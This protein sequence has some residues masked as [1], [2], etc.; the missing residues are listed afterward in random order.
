MSP[1]QT[2]SFPAHHVPHAKP[3]EHLTALRVFLSF[4]LT[5]TLVA[6]GERGLYDLNRLFNPLYQV[7]NQAQ[8]LLS[9]GQ[10]CQVESYAFKELLLHSYISFPLFVIFLGLMLYLRHHRLSTWQRALFRVS[11]AVAIIFGVQF[12]L[13]VVFFLFRFHQV[14]AWYFSLGVVAVLLMTLVIYLERR[15]ARKHAAGQEHH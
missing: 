11:S 1:I 13:E 9:V 4:L 3:K 12:L 6:L 8:Y 5:L 2:V 10:S 7:C 14:E 15:Q